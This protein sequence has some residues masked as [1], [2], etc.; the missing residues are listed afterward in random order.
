MCENSQLKILQINGLAPFRTKMQRN[1]DEKYASYDAFFV[2]TPL[3]PKLI[4]HST[5]LYLVNKL[6]STLSVDFKSQFTIS[7]KKTRK[8]LL[9]TL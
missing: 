3:R 4:L 2:K 8:K 7:R 6:Y 9:V 5:F 1:T